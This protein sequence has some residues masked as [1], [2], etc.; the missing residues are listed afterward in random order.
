MR[1]TRLYL[2]II[3]ARYNDRCEIYL[4]A[5]YSSKVMVQYKV[6]RV[7]TEL[8]KLVMQPPNQLVP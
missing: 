1:W 3:A 8:C 2:K 4:R 6:F 7:L 5:R